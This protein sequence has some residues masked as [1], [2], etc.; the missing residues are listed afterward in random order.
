[1]RG[2]ELSPVNVRV[3]KDVLATSRSQTV[4]NFLATES[5]NLV[6]KLRGVEPGFVPSAG[7]ESSVAAPDLLFKEL[8]L[9]ASTSGRR[10]FPAVAPPK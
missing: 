5:P 4:T 2:V 1:V 3:W 9:R 8:G 10:P 6:F 7:V